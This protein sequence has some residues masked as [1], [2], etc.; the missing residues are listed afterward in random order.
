MSSLPVGAVALSRALRSGELSSVEATREYL[1]RIDRENA[2]LKA[3]VHVDAEGALAQARDADGRIRTGVPRSVMDG[4]PIAVKDNIDIAG[5]PT[6]GGIQHYR[7]VIPKEDAFVIAT[8]RDAG[9]VLLGKL[10]MHEGALGGTTDNPWFGRCEN[11]LRTGYT[12]G[13]SSGGSGAAVA[14]GLCAAALGTDTLGSVR[15]PAAYCGVTGIKPT[16]GLLSTRGVMPI[17]ATFDHVGYLA[18]CV[19]DSRLL[20]RASAQFD[21]DWPLARAAPYSTSWVRNHDSVG[22]LRVGVLHD[23]PGTT[24]EPDVRATYDEAIHALQDA[25]ATPVALSLPDYAFDKVRRDCL[26]LIEMEGSTVHSEAI[27]ANPSGFSAEFRAMIAFG[28]KQT[29]ARAVLSYRRLRELRAM[30][31]EVMRSVD[32]LLLPTAPQTA[33]P[34]SP[35]PPVN[36][37][38][39]CGI[40]NILEAPAGCI[41]WGTGQSGMPLSIQIVGQRFEDDRV[42]DALRCMER[43]APRA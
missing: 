31:E 33:F 30:L 14:A 21:R 36:Q 41:P 17:A 37:A 2:R 9:A 10:N 42:L 18:S 35:T 16:Y 1:A 8:L 39:L 6:A 26:L 43:L 34:F 32:V 4:V 15:I 27:A 7:H 29:A 5:M 22:G 20:L 12:A 19:E 24:V 23:F 11:P 3:F 38:D 25:G 40:A 28:A 13:G